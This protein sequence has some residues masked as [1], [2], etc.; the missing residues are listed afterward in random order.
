M[1]NDMYVAFFFDCL[2][3]KNEPEI[4]EYEYIKKP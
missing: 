3:H 1:H 4:N 2:S